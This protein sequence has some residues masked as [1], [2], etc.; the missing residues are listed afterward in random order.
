MNNT[1]FKRVISSA[2]AM[3]MLAVSPLTGFAESADGAAADNEA[4]LVSESESSSDDVSSEESSR[5]GKSF[6]RASCSQFV[7]QSSRARRS[8]STTQ[9]VSRSS[10]AAGRSARR[11]KDSSIRPSTTGSG[12]SPRCS[13][14][15]RRRSAASFLR[16]FLTP[17]CHIPPK[18][19]KKPSTP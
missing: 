2:V 16:S 6:S 13:T 5:T 4:S 11:S 12:I 9:R 15:Q 10:P 17:S 7:P 14:G 1:Y 3:L 19:K 8:A 18:C